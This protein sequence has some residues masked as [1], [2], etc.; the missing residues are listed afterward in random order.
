MR[1]GEIYRDGTI[2][3]QRFRAWQLAGRTAGIVG[4]GAVG[5]AA[6]WRLE[7]LGMRVISYDPF[8]PTPRTRST[9]CSPKPTSSRCTP[10]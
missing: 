2:P 3:Y 1:E 4:L 5:R 10:R 7:G 8:A 6:A 9:T